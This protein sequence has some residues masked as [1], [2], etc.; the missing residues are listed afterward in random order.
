MTP[1][2]CFGVWETAWA[3]YDVETA[4]GKDLR[5][6]QLYRPFQALLTASGLQHFGLG[7]QECPAARQ[8]EGIVHSYIQVSTAR[9]TAY[10]VM[11]DGTQAIFFSSQG[12]LIGGA[13]SRMREL[14]L[15]QTGEYFGIRFQ[16]G[17]LRHFF[18]LDLAEITD[19]FADSGYFPSREFFEPPDK[20]FVI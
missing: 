20:H 11:P 8:L 9:P 10:P 12:T 14:Q 19:Q 7:M 16:P 17:A 4:K 2:T 5:V 18:K 13:L 3:G 6:S 1:V 15:L